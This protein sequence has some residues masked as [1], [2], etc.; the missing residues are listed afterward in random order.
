VEGLAEQLGK[1]LGWSQFKPLVLK[2]GLSRL[3]IVREI[4]INYRLKIMRWLSGCYQELHQGRSILVVLVLSL[5][6]KARASLPSGVPLLV[7]VLLIMSRNHLSLAVLVLR[8]PIQLWGSSARDMAQ[9]RHHARGFSRIIEGFEHLESTPQP[10]VRS[11]QWGIIYA[12]E[13][14]GNA[15]IVVS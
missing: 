4:S 5:D 9:V 10:I 2:I 8:L 15:G 7:F 11:M 14:H 1:V 13:I 12:I 3:I 6:K